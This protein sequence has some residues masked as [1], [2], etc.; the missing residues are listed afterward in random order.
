MV[1][2][3]DLERAVEGE[4]LVKKRHAEPVVMVFDKRHE[5]TLRECQA[6]IAT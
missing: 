6:M 2:I 5:S 1:G 4:S 3:E